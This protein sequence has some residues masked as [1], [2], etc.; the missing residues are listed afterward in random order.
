MFTS[1]LFVE[2]LFFQTRDRKPSKCDRIYVWGID[3]L[4]TN[5]NRYYWDALTFHSQISHAK[6]VAQIYQSICTGDCVCCRWCWIFLSCGMS[7]FEDYLHAS[8]MYVRFEHFAF[9]INFFDSNVFHHRV[10]VFYA[11]HEASYTN[12]GHR[13]AARPVSCK[14]FVRFYTVIWFD[15]LFNKFVKSVVSDME[16]L[17]FCRCC[18]CGWRGYCCFYIT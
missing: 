7:Q 16:S 4:A 5:S 13:L 3:V 10:R 11:R 17:T 12:M 1:F 6:C 9:I 8:P 15:F 18:C 2:S 14:N